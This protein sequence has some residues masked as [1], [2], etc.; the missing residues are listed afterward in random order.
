MTKKELIATIQNLR[1]EFN[2]IHS[3]NLGVIRGATDTTELQSQIK[4]LA[5]QA[6]RRGIKI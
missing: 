5:D 2:R 1:Q 6:R 3:L 4:R